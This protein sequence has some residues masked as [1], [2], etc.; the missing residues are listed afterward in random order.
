MKTFFL[1]ILGLMIVIV[2]GLMLSTNTGFQTSVLNT[3]Q[4]GQ[5]SIKDRDF[6]TISDPNRQNIKAKIKIEVAKNNDEKAK[7]LGGRESLDQESGMLFVYDVKLK[8]RFWMKGMKIPLDFIWIDG[9]KVADLL[10]NVPPPQEGQPDAT[11]QLYSSTVDVDKVLE[12]NAGF[13][14]R[15]NIIVGDKIDF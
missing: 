13:I 2:V 7:G 14:S 10:E 1:Q 5:N 8:P 15:N 6:L 11:L 12:V 3:F 9:D 4:G